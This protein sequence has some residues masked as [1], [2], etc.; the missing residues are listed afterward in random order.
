MAETFNWTVKNNVRIK[1]KPQFKK[2][3][4]GEG[5]EQRTRKGINTDLPSYSVTIIPKPDEI[6]AVDS[7]LKAHNGVDFFEWTQA[8]HASPI[9]V[10]CETWTVN[11]ETHRATITAVFRQVVG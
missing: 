11:D 6:E 8:R 2:T 4:F 10:V 9:R 7:F 1:H 3:T 5:Y